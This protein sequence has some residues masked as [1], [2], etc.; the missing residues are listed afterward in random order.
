MS[1]EPMSILFVDD[2]E[3]FLSSA[4]DD[5]RF[6]L[7]EHEIPIEISSSNTVDKGVRKLESGDFHLAIVDL[8]F[9]PSPRSGNEV[10][11][12]I[13]DT[14]I[15]PI[16][17]LSGFRNELKDEFSEHGLIYNT[18]RKK[19]DEVVDKII[20]WDHKGVFDFFSEA[21]FLNSRL[22]DVLQHTMWHHVS[23]YWE[24]IDSDNPLVLHRIAG[25]IAA[26]ILHDVLASTPAYENDGGEVLVHHGEAYIFNTP[27]NHLAVGDMLHLE[28]SMFVVLSP[29]CDLIV[30][31][32]GGTKA[33][34]VLLADC[35]NLGTFVSNNQ[36]I[37][38]QI[39][40]MRDPEKTDARKEK[41]SKYLE[42]LMRQD[43]ENP[44][45]RYFYLPPFGDFPGGVVDFLKVQVEPYDVERLVE[46]RIVSLNRE[47]AAELATRFARYMIRLGQPA[48]DPIF[49]INAVCDTVLAKDGT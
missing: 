13:L 24:H 2:D 44:S 39:E 31:P 22:R 45:G 15:L 38:A 23:R 34:E 43:W 46:Q 20:E 19:V 10:I 49:L 33:E 3:D 17:V 28:D 11:E 14:K 35:H 18:Q 37:L 7:E 5:L 4:Q 42:R 32:S 29:T 12:R 25:R 47:L 6:S 16:I 48:Y 40:T 30:R 36:S 8:K 21:G 27:R 26:T 9:T 41:A 1:R